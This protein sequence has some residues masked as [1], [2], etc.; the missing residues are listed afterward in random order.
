MKLMM[1]RMMPTSPWVFVTLTLYMLMRFPQLSRYCFKSLSWNTH[2]QE[3]IT[4]GDLMTP[5][6]MLLKT[7]F[8]C[9]CVCVCVYAY[10]VLKHQ[11]EGAVCVYN[12]MQGNDVC[13]FQ[14]LQ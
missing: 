12:I 10:Q 9:L 5:S 1:K 6:N 8:V 3:I 13:M 14:V 4:N 11:C 2:R 7:G